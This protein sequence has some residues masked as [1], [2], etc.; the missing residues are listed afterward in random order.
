MSNVTE[1]F[2]FTYLY[3]LVIFHQVNV[4]KIIRYLQHSKYSSHGSGPLG[5]PAPRDSWASKAP[6]ALTSRSSTLSQRSN[7]ATSGRNGMNKSKYLGATCVRHIIQ[8]CVGYLLDSL[9]PPVPPTLGKTTLMV[10]REAVI[11][12]EVR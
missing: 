4:L 2:D 7:A 12:G 9:G 11:N 1:R 5:N 10:L 6:P 3:S 8:H